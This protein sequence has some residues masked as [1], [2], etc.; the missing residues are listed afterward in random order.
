MRFRKNCAVILFT[1]VTLFQTTVAQNVLNKQSG[2][3]HLKSNLRFLASDLLEGRETATRGEKLASLFIAGELEKYGVKPFGDDGTYFQNFELSVRGTD[4]ESTIT[5]IDSEGGENKLKLG[6]DFY[7][8]LRNMPSEKYSGKVYEVVFAG[9]GITNDSSDYD[10]Y[11]GVDVDGKVVLL[12]MGTP[13]KD[14]KSLFPDKK[15]SMFTQ[16]DYKYNN[17][18]KHGA[19]G[20]LFLPDDM[21]IK[22]WKFLKRRSFSSSV[23]LIGNG[24]ESMK[25]KDGIPLFI[26]SEDAATA[27][28]AN[29]KLSYEEIMNQVNEEKPHKAFRLSKKIQ[30]DYKIYSETKSARN[31][32]GLIEGTDPNLKNELVVMSAHYDHLGKKDGEIYNGADDDGSGTVTVLEAARRLS[33]LKQNKRPV[34][35]VFHTGEE[36]GLLGSEYLTN[37]SSFIENVV[38]DINIDMVGRGSIDSVF[39]IGSNK[40]ST[41][42]YNLVKEANAGTVNFVLDYTFDD[43]NDPN[44]YYYRSD[45]YNYARKN[46][47]V[48]FFYDHMLEDY[49]Q[50]TDDT[51]KINFKK[52]DKMSTLVT[53]LALKIAN[54]KHRLIVDKRED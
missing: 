1:I 14:G 33:M 44:R 36:K 2:I 51:E 19:T 11:K 38:A 26:L 23:N 8:S 43:P 45:H 5:I 3:T 10:D 53:A 32:I 48:V 16:S 31:V 28:L 30:T 6:D 15:F 7:L 20:V 12:L 50:P 9:Y 49:H 29:E 40:L 25:E 54:F 18:V 52:L 41:E 34:L 35:A 37:N 27:L 24:E 13:K 47:P 42:L 39:C 4:K 17:A 22:Y 21:M 46:I